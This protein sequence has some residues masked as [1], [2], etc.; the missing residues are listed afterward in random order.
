MRT[1]SL[2]RRDLPSAVRNH[3]KEEF[4]DFDSHSSMPG[5]LEQFHRTRGDG[6]V[7]ENDK[8]EH[9]RGIPVED[10]CPEALV[11]WLPGQRATSLLQSPQTVSTD[12]W[13]KVHTLDWGCFSNFSPQRNQRDTFLKNRFLECIPPNSESVG[14][15]WDLRVCVSSRPPC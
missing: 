7:S 1:T 2:P 13:N 4:C 10:R 11:C 9:S 5:N 3:F 6:Q 12:F 15:G 14:A 8:W